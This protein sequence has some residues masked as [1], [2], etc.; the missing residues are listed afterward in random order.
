MKTLEITHDLTK[1]L[2]IAI[3]SIGILGITNDAYAAIPQFDTFVADDPDDADNTFS[4]GDTL[5]I[6]FDI[7]TNATGSGTMTQS[8]IDANF[9]LAGGGTPD[10]GTTYTGT[11]SAD[12][13]TLTITVS[14]ASGGSLTVDTTTVAGKATTTIADADGG[15]ADLID[16]GGDTATLTGDF[17]LFVALTTTQ[18]G[19]SS[20]CKGDCQPPTLGVSQSGKRLV[21]NGF[22]YNGNAI[23]VERFFTPYPLITVNVG[24]RNLAEFK[25]YE[26]G[27]PDDIRHF[28]LA[29]GIAKGQ[30]MS[31]SKAIIEWDKNFAGI[32]TLNVIDPQNSLQEV[33]IDTSTTKCTEDSN[34]EDGC[35]LV[36]VYHTFRAPLDFN[37]VGSKVWDEKRHGWQNY[38][39]HGIEVQGKS[40]NPPM[41][42]EV[43]YG[44]E[45]FTITETGKNIAVDETGNTWNFDKSWTKDY[46]AP[47]CTDSFTTHGGFDRHNCLF[48]MYMKGQELV[49]ST[50]MKEMYPQF[51]SEPF[52][53]VNDIA[54]SPVPE[55]SQDTKYQGN[56]LQEILKAEETYKRLYSVLDRITE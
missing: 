44:G 21:D 28:E 30:L 25:I 35:L 14:D 17:G 20:G 31:D 1:L 11:W 43:R 23:D 3:V 47:Q 46:K 55:T 7:A 50:A 32:E 10:F 8:E 29:F 40:M 12:S 42:H 52:E 56:T 41:Q 36:K 39:N 24:E 26:N 6:N 2:L 38:F 13:K 49:A 54:L 48:G 34:N 5:T 53:E 15:N 22:T 4:D 9:T 19:S 27:G 16:N 45:T 51:F 33:T 18:A 37:I